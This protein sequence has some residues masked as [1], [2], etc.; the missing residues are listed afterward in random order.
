[1]TKMS[2]AE[3]DAMFFGALEAELYAGQVSDIPRLQES[4]AMRETFGKERI[5][6]IEHRYWSSRKGL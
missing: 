5:R 2:D 6:R 3:V 4:S 1:M